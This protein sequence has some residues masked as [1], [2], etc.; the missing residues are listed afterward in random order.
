MA[1]YFGFDA[2]EVELYNDP[3]VFISYKREDAE[4]VAVYA[5]YLRDNGI[6]VWYDN[7]LHAGE[8]WES[9]LMSVIEKDN[10]KT[11]LLFVSSKVADSTVIPLETTQ[12]RICK[13]PTVAVYLEGGLDLEKLLSKAIKVYVEQRQSVNAYG[14]SE[15]SICSEILSAAKKAMENAT[16]TTQRSADELWNNARVFINNAGRSRSVED[17]QTAQSYLGTMTRQF[18]ADYRGWLGLAMC[19]CRMP[20]KSLDEG[21]ERLWGAAKYYSYVVSIGADEAASAQYT[22]AKD[23]LWRRVLELMTEA[24]ETCPDDKSAAELKEKVAV[25][26]K[27]LGHTS[28]TIQRGYNAV[29]ESFNDIVGIAEDMAAECQWKALSKK[30]TALAKY[31]GGGDTYIIP[32]LAEGRRVVR[33]EKNAFKDH[34]ELKTVVIP[35][36]VR[37]IKKTAFAGCGELVLKGRGGFC[38]PA[39]RYAKRHYAKKRK[40]S[41]EE[42]KD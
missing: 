29:L 15:G 5:K 18:P 25:F 42:I 17:V 19:Q 26:G 41:F 8:D 21:L 33:I 37:K 7:G 38:S 13:K 20:V 28:P 40:I 4:R 11:M 12:A 34:A 36:S 27:S 14:S 30:K 6:N 31:N 2:Y 24:F 9:Y 1:S 10:C 22:N 16:E 39:R 3:F 32:D 35:K 23:D